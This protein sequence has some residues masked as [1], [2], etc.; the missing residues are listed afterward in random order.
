MY[1][2]WIWGLGF[3]IIGDLDRLGFVFKEYKE[4]L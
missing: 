3:G 4:Y 2:C 1:W